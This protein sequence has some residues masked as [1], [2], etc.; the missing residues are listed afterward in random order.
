MISSRVVSVRDI[1]YMINTDSC[2][3]P[4]MTKAAIKRLGLAYPQYASEIGYALG[5]RAS[6]SVWGVIIEHNN[7]PVLVLRNLMC[8]VSASTFRRVYRV[9]ISDTCKGG[10]CPPHDH[11]FTPIPIDTCVQAQNNQ[12]HAESCPSTSMMIVQ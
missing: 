12:M 11:P 8:H 1:D 9:Q 2:Y 5:S 6:R 3:I 4:C 7:Q 10:L